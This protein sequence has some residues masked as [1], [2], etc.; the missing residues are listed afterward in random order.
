MPLT[1]TRSFR[2]RLTECDIHEIARDATYLRYIQEAAFDASTAAGYDQAWYLAADRMWLIRETRMDFVAPLRF[3]ETV[4]VTTWV[5]DF[6]RVRSRRAY[7]LRCN[8]ELVAQ[9]RTDWAFLDRTTGRPAVIPADVV[10]GFFPEGQSGDGQSRERFPAAPPVPAGVFTERR[11]VEWRDLDSVGHVNN[12]AYGDYVED[13]ARRAASFHGW[14]AARLA[15]EGID[16]ATQHLRVEYRQ[17]AFPDDELEV[18]TW[19]S[20]VSEESAL[21]HTTVMRASDGEML[22]QA[23]VRWG[24]VEL[25]SRKRVSLPPSLC[26]DMRDNTSSD[27]A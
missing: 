15:D 24:C 7:E 21:R 26:S 25:K 17:P 27:V 19:L 3:G 20:E 9:G 8:G 13:A 11:R 22:A 1:Y 23:Y 16:L 10:A 6:R 14:P 5:A 12:A 18:S 2:V 4:D